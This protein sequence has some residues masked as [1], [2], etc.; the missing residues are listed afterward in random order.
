MIIFSNK[1]ILDYAFSNNEEL[2]E[3]I[4]LTFNDINKFKLIL[5]SELI[6]YKEENNLQTK[7]YNCINFE[8]N[9]L[10]D[11]DFFELNKE[12]LRFTNDIYYVGEDNNK[13]KKIEMIYNDEAVT[14]SLRKAR[15]SI[16]CKKKNKVKKITRN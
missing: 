10:M 9:A 12:Y 16:R 11:D 3:A 4:M 1:T 5:A 15:L 6:T 7:K 8:Q 13:A 14:H 2:E